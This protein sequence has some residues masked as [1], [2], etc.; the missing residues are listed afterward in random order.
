MN[1]GEIFVFDET[2]PKEDRARIL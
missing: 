1:T 2:M